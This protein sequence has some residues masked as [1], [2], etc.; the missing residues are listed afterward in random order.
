MDQVNRW[1]SQYPRLAYN[2]SWNNLWKNYYIKLNRLA[3]NKPGRI[4]TY[5]AYERTRDAFNDSFNDM[6]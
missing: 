1:E 6:K 3:Y 5:S 2:T 4:T